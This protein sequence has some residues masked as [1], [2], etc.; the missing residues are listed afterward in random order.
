MG[1]VADIVGGVADVVGSVVGGVV[2]AV[3]SV[4]NALGPI[5]TIAAAYF[6]MPYLAPS[7]FAALSAPSILGG[8]MTGAGMMTSGALSS[9]IGGS[10]L[11]AAGGAG[12][13]SA[14]SG[15]NS[16]INGLGGFTSA[17]PN[18]SSSFGSIVNSLS[19]FAQKGSSS[20]MP[21]E[22]GGMPNAGGGTFDKLSKLIRGGMDI[23]NA[24]QY[25]PGQTPTAAQ[26]SADPYAPYRAQAA[27]KLNEL[28][29]DPSLVYGL[30]GYNFAQEEGTKQIGRAAAATGQSIS[31]NTLAA[32][33]KQSQG[34]AKTWFDDYVNNLSMQSGANQNPAGGQAAYSTAAN[35]QSL[36]EK[37]KK[38]AQMQGVLGLGSALTSFFA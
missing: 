37:S 17:T 30:P 23:Y 35:F 12:V 38:D 24:T 36:A 22:S 20:L 29:A 32:I 7:G 11:S 18:A 27:T 10:L 15:A 9:G 3:G 5:G 19:N 25:G 21:G 13:S 8:E 26:S 4:A 6:G 28:M 16:F 1:F 33:N 14:F 34:T 2:D 31:G